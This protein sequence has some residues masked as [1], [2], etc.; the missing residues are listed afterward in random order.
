MF[1][2]SKDLVLTPLKHN[3]NTTEA[4]VRVGGVADRSPRKHDRTQQII[5]PGLP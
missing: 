3:G 2:E 1:T 5:L 4:I